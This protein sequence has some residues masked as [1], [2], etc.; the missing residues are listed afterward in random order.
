MH[1]CLFLAP[2]FDVPLYIGFVLTNEYLTPLYAFHK[3]SAPT[4]FVALSITISDWSKV[5]HEIEKDTRYSLMSRYFRNIYFINDTTLLLVNFLSLGLAFVN[6]I[7]IFYLNDLGVYLGSY[8]YIIA[9]FSQVAVSFLLTC[10][11]LYAG[12]KLYFRIRGV[13][14][15]V[16]TGGYSQLGPAARVQN[17][18]VEF[19][20][21]LRSLNFV[22]ATCSLFIFIQVKSL[23]V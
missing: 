7:Y 20:S 8:L 2:L 3:L 21:A 23:H 19:K 9:L 17:V 14:G 12:M 18:S 6:F 10:C 11:M 22:M 13:A 16:D 4:L 1:V 5:L 15:Q